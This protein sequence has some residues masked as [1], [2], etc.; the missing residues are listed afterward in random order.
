VIWN[1]SPASVAW[2]EAVTHPGVGENVTR[3]VLF[4]LKLLAQMADEHAQV[5]W[6][7]HAVFAPNRGKQHAMRKHFSGVLRQINEKVKFLRSEAHFAIL[8]VNRAGGK[9][10]AEVP[11]LD[12]LRLGLLRRNLL[13]YGVGGIVVPF[14]G[15]KLIDMVITQ[16]GLA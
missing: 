16:V 4:W 8:D 15:I 9:V 11:D 3:T 14:I 13:L 12:E 6:L 10:Y 7:L 1:E 2:L 5:F